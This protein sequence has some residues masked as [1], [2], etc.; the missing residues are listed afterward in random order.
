MRTPRDCASTVTF[1]F[2]FVRLSLSATLALGTYF[3]ARHLLIDQRERTA[4]RQAYADAALVRDSLL[5][6]GAE[7]SDVLG[8]L[9]PPPGR[10]STSGATATGT[11][12]RSTAPAREHG[13][14]PAAVA[15]GSVGVGWT[16][17]T[18][19]NAVVVGIPLPAVDAEYYEVVVADELDQTLW[20]L[21]RP[22]DLRRPH[23]GSGSVA[24]TG[25]EPSRARSAARAWPPLPGSPRE[26]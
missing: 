21:G 23:D 20:T 17:A 11:P 25:R 7:I 13:R 26:T 15:D 9:S 14:G 10:R 6:P 5:T 22:G 12:R 2:A 8:A 19:R 3:S 1:A 4:T 16:E 24:R 18:S